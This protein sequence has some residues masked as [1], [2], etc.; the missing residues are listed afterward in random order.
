M[1]TPPSRRRGVAVAACI[2]SLA[3]VLA[4]CTGD[5]DPASAPSQVPNSPGVDGTPAPEP[6]GTPVPAPGGG[7][8]GAT[9]TATQAP[10]PLAEEIGEAAEVS[11]GVRVSIA[12][13][14]AVTASS[15]GPGEVAGP[16]V[17]VTVAVTNDTT[18]PFDL[19]LVSV[20][21]TDSEGLPGS[22]MTGEP[23]D[24]LT[25]SIEPGASAQGV[26]VFTVPEDHRDPVHVDVSVDPTLPTVVFTGEAN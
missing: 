4:G 3:M 5:P 25:G 14:A 15:T 6:P 10:E 8:V 11:D 26:Y 19:A 21:L 9:V 13:V 2:A 24:W 12:D 1:T 22:G 23:A 16:A 20:N 17:A 7:D 18:E